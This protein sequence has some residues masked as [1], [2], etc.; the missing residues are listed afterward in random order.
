MRGKTQELSD[1][2][3]AQTLVPFTIKVPR[4]WETMPSVERITFTE[5]D[6]GERNLS[7]T[8]QAWKPSSEWSTVEMDIEFAQ[9]NQSIVEYLQAGLVNACAFTPVELRNGQGFTFW[10]AGVGKSNAA[11]VIWQEGD[12]KFSIWLYGRETMPT[13]NNPHPFDRLLLRLADSMKPL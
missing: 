13:E 4:D 10:D 3:T 1:L 6:N 5:S 9:S 8:Y 2:A 7:L 11:V 12:L